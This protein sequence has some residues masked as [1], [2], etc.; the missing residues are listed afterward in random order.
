MRS[1]MTQAI[2]MVCIIFAA[3]LAFRYWNTD[4]P[5]L[6]FSLKLPPVST[7]L[8]KDAAQNP[9]SIVCPVSETEN[10]DAGPQWNIPPRPTQSDFPQKALRD[11]V[12]GWAKVVCKAMPDGSVKDC[13]VAEEAPAYYGFG[14]SAIKVVQRGCLTTYPPES[15]PKVFTVRVPYNL[16]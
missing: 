4:L 5:K 16:Y 8:Q 6:D 10:P 12:A 15:A 2:L 7:Y 13:Q 3:V 1:F 14:E 9:V 11:G